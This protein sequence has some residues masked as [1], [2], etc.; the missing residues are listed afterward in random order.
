MATLKYRMYVDEVGNADLLRS[1][2]S[3]HRFPAGVGDV[4]G[5]AV[6]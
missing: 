6:D 5:L 1:G 3:N 4:A 2:N